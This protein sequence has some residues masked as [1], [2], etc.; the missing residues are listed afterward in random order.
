MLNILFSSLLR[1]NYVQASRALIMLLLQVECLRLL[2]NAKQLSAQLLQEPPSW[3]EQ[4]S[5]CAKLDELRAS[6]DGAAQCLQGLLP[7]EERS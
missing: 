2:V 1:A 4:S 5:I 6:I 7:Y 3:P